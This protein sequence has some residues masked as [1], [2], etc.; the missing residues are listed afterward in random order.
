MILLR[1][2]FGK[3]DFYYLEKNLSF[4]IV[5]VERICRMNRKKLFLIYLLNANNFAVRKQ[6]CTRLLTECYL[7]RNSATTTTILDSLWSFLSTIVCMC[8]CV[9]ICT[10]SSRSNVE[11]W[12]R[13]KSRKH[14]RERDGGMWYAIHQL[15]LM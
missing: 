6:Y 14:L 10:H 1:K 15:M 9:C 11:M 12:S 2:K 8:K 5:V 4:V 13:A 7:A 3:K